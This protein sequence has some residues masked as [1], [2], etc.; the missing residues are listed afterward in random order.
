MDSERGASN[1]DS[2]PAEF[3]LDADRAGNGRA[4][5]PADPHRAVRGKYL[6][7]PCRRFYRQPDD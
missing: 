1:D 2:D 4:G 3:N 5:I 7:Q 6:G